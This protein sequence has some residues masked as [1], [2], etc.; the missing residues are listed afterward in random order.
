ML[1]PERVREL[2]DEGRRLRWAFEERIAP[3]KVPVL[4]C[5]HAGARDHHR[6]KPPRS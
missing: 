2:L 4:E 1:T 6:P 3:M 5:P